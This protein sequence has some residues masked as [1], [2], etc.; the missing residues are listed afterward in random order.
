LT[1]DTLR[2]ARL[3]SYGYRRPTTPSLDRLLA[4]GARFAQARTVEPLTTPALGA[5]LTSLYPHEHGATRNGLRL[6]P[7][8]PSFAR[9][10]GRRGFATAA[11]S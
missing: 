1:V 7:G 5:L 4:Q 3:S 9:A 2:A 11:S 6:A 8:L 10:L